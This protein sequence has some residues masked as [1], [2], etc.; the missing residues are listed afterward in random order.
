MTSFLVVQSQRV[1]T[2]SHPQVAGEGGVDW[3]ESGSRIFDRQRPDTLHVKACKNDDTFTEGSSSAGV[4]QY[5][6]QTVFTRCL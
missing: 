5:L 4:E 1:A 6:R 3:F 2:A